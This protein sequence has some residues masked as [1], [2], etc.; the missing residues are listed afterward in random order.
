[1]GA[2]ARSPIGSPASRPTVLQDLVQLASRGQ[3]TT[4]TAGNDEEAEN[5]AACARAALYRWTIRR[6]CGTPAVA[7]GTVE[8]P[9]DCQSNR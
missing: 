9:D 1:M 4:N 8:A 5:A 2:A 3:A 6:V 7:V